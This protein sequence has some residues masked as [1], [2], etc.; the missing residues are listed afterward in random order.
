SGGGRALVAAD[1]ARPRADGD[2]ERPEIADP[3]RIGQDRPSLR[4]AA[5]SGLAAAAPATPSG[6]NSP[7]RVSDSHHTPRPPLTASSHPLSAQARTAPG[8]GTQCAGYMTSLLVAYNNCRTTPR[9]EET[10][11]DNS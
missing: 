3:P 10:S 8:A 6:R 2:G 11:H 4:L 9:H 7:W 5:R 1:A